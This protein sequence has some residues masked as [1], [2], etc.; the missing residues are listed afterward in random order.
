MDAVN[1]RMVH[2][3]AERHR[4]SASGTNREL[5]HAKQVLVLEAVEEAAQFAFDLGPRL[6]DGLGRRKV[7]R[8]EAR[9]SGRT[10][11]TLEPTGLRA[12]RVH[13]RVAYGPVAA[14]DVA[15]KFLCRQLADDI[16]ELLI[17]PGAIRVQDL[18]IVDSHDA[19]LRTRAGCLRYSAAAS[20]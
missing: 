2:Q 14:G 1:R 15:R 12:Q 13:H 8:I 10:A 5:D 17:G 19:S 11:A 7:R 20:W 9:A 18:E 16:K 6:P 3:L 4:V